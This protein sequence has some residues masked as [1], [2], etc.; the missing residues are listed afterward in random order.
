ME[1]AFAPVDL[2]DSAMEDEWS[3]DIGCGVKYFSQDGIIKLAPAA[4]IDLSGAD[5]PTEKL[6][7][8]QAKMTVPNFKKISLYEV[9]KLFKRLLQRTCT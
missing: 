9:Y 8:V 5:T 7:I 4:G 3:G 6:K 1:L 2:A